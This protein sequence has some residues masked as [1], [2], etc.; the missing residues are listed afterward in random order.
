[1]RRKNQKNGQ[2]LLMSL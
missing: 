1:L 2:A